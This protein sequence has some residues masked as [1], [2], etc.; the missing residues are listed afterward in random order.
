MSVSLKETVNHMRHP[1]CGDESEPGIGSTKMLHRLFLAL[2]YTTVISGFLGGGMLGNLAAARPTLESVSPNAAAPNF[3][4]NRVVPVILTV[5]NLATRT[6]IVQIGGDG[7]V[8]ASDVRVLP[9]GR[10]IEANFNILA[11]AAIGERDVRVVDPANG[12]SDP[13]PFTI[14]FIPT[15]MLTSIL[16]NR[17][18]LNAAGPR[19]VPVII[20]GTN[21]WDSSSVQISGTGVKVSHP[22]VGVRRTSTQ[23]NATFTIA[24]NARVGPRDVTVTNAGGGVRRVSRQLPFTVTAASN[25]PALARITPNSGLRRSVNSEVPFTITGANLTGGRVQIGTSWEIQV[26]R[27]N[28]ISATQISGTFRIPPNAAIGVRGVTV[29]T[30][31]GPSNSLTFTVN[32]ER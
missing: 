3:P 16:P 10:R 27:A 5:S 15:P 22:N 18:A 32:R 13:V 28:V 23:I 19:E 25:A 14:L 26:L 29:T 20:Q 24:R 17:G 6:P 31:N 21:F 1:I 7:R 2:V 30:P 4:G 11:N 8:T 12:R 9:S